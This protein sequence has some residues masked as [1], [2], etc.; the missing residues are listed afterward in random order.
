MERKAAPAYFTEVAKMQ[1]QEAFWEH[2]RFLTLFG[3][4][5]W[6]CLFY[7]GLRKEKRYRRSYRRN[8]KPGQFLTYEP[9]DFWFSIGTSTSTSTSSA[10]SS[11]QGNI[12]LN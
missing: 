7:S 3:I 9:G 4:K 2:V 1:I 8:N 11:A 12:I 5:G 10:L 6:K